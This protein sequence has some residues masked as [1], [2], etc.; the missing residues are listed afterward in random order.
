M[1]Y[2]ASNGLMSADE[3]DRVQNPSVLN[4]LQHTECILEYFTGQ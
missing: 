1:G 4:S 3:S 2:I